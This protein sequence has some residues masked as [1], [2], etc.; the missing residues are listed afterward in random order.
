LLAIK[1]KTL[2]ELVYMYQQV[3]SSKPSLKER[4]PTLEQVP[5]AAKESDSDLEAVAAGLEE[6]NDGLSWLDEPPPKT[7]NMEQ[8]VFSIKD[9]VELGSLYLL[10]LLNSAPNPL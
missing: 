5:N 4:L 1:K 3:I 6:I 9:T 8:C 2:A 7:D 10:D